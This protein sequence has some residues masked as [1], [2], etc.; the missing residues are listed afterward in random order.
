MP[1]DGGANVG[2]QLL[3]VPWLLHEVLRASADG[4]HHVRH[5]AVRRNH[6]HRQRRL[7]L[8]NARQQVDAVLTG[9]RQV[10]QQQVELARS[11]LFDP[12]RAVRSHCDLEAL[13][14]EQRVE[15]FSDRQLV[16]HDQNARRANHAR[17]RPHQA[18]LSRP[19]VLGNCR[20]R[21]HSNI[22]FRH[23]H[24][25]LCIDSRLQSRLQPQLRSSIETP[26]YT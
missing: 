5:L 14:A 26:L 4:V 7:H 25:S 1:P 8:Q 22:R 21:I 9:Q 15:R 19:L 20:L 23:G 11:Q 16:V 10:Q 13:Q 17:V 6:D 24:S 2:Q 18:R 12:R 3:V